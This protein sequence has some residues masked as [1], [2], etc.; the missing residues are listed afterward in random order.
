LKVATWNVNGMRARRPQFLDWI[1]VEQPDIV[2][3]QEIKASPEQL[4]E[5]VCQLEG[6]QCYW[7][8]LG[9][10]SGVS[11]QV[12]RGT[13]AGELSFAHPAFDRERRVVTVCIGELLVASVYVPNGGKNFD[14]K[15]LF[16]REMTEWVAET[17]A[18]GKQVILCGDL[19]VTRTA[20]DVHPRERNEKLVG[21]R[22]VER[23]L[24]EALLGSGLIDLGR[25]LHPDDEGLFTWWAPWREHR[26]RNIGW[27]ID[28]ILATE[29]VAERT[30][31]YEIRR[32]VGTSDHGPVVATFELPAR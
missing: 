21:Q 5:D 16:L 15:L 24:F 25:E 7:H 20:M 27:R 13:F 30:T 12:R 9:A 18:A 19:N 29:G 8:C 10:Y 4:A 11:L 3:L 31:S 32:E 22:P 2:C 28:Y 26:Q 6:Y 1:A 17:R 23:Q 14:D